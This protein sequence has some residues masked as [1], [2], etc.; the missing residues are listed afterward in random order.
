MNNTN[1]CYFCHEPCGAGGFCDE[2]CLKHYDLEMDAW[3]E[4]LNLEEIGEDDV[5]LE[6]HNE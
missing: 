2:N 4:W 6:G 1:F 5:V 3:H